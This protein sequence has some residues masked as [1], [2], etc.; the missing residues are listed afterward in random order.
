M[1]TVVGI[2]DRR[3]CGIILI[4]HDLNVILN[5]CDRVVVLNEGRVIA[6]GTPEEVRHDPAVIRAY[7]G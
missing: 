5:A 1:E 3:G 2:R 7:L 6:R 4:D